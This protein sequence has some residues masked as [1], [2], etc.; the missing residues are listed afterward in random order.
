MVAA[1]VTHMNVRHDVEGRRFVVSLPEGDGEI[2]YDDARDGVID[3]LHTEV[4]AGLRGRGV[5]GELVRAAL[6][7]A[8][9]HDLRVVP[10]CPYVRRYLDEH[11]DERASVRI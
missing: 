3:L 8:R 6:A 5:A 9:E 2:V 10:S 1:P 7:Y 4:S 11:P